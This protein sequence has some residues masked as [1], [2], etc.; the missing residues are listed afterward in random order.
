MVR[1]YKF[2]RF[3]A[4]GLMEEGIPTIAWYYI[5]EHNCDPGPGL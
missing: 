2:V 5:K 1:A 3:P 4:K